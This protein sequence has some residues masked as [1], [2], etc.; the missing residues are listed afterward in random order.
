M[1]TVPQLDSVS[2][3]QATDVIM[4]THADGTTEKITGENFMKAMAVDVIAE[5]NMYSVTSNAVAKAHKIIANTV[6]SYIE[7]GNGV[8]SVDTGNSTGY[9]L[10]KVTLNQYH[11]HLEP[12]RFVAKANPPQGYFEVFKFG[13][14]LLQAFSESKNI[15]FGTENV[16]VMW[17]E[18]IGTYTVVLCFIDMSTK[19][20]YVR[21]FLPFNQNFAIIEG[22]SY[23]IIGD[24][25]LYLQ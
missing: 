20:L 5:N 1:I 23:T 18:T 13:N 17:D 16:F 24:I 10:S 3:I 25:D 21:T 8:A 6:N 7:K 14:A 2:Q 9:R 15:A 12:A 11:I 4:I 22:H 19:S